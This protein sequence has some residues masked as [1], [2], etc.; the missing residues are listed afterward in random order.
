VRPW[1]CA[2]VCRTGFPIAPGPRRRSSVSHG[3]SNPV[4][5]RPRSS[6]DRF[7][8]KAALWQTEHTC[9]QRIE[10][11]EDNLLAR[12]LGRCPPPTR[13]RQKLGWSGRAFNGSSPPRC[14]GWHSQ[15]AM[16]Q[17]GIGARSRSQMGLWRTSTNRLCT[18][19]IHNTSALSASRSRISTTPHRSFRRLRRRRPGFAPSV[20]I[21]GRRGF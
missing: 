20:D 7:I 19:R 4:S 14:P 15:M 2:R 6:Q 17:Y 1:H 21:P 5:R 18:K 16:Q 12:G 13:W 9:E 11:T 3:G 10:S 8:S